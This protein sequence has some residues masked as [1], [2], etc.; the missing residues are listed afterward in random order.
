MRRFEVLK[1]MHMGPIKRD[2]RPGDVIG[3]DVPSK[4]MTLN[5]NKLTEEKGMDLAEVIGIFERQEKLHPDGPWAKEMDAVNIT[6]DQLDVKTGTQVVLPI[7]GCLKAAEE[8]LADKMGWGERKV[9]WTPQNENQYQ[10]LQRFLAS[11]PVVNQLGENLKYMADR[12]VE[13]INAWLKANDF[14]IQLSPESGDSFAVASILDVL[15]HWLTEGNVT[16]FSYQDK[17]YPAVS[18]NTDEGA[19]VVKYVNRANH[20]FPIV[21]LGTKTGDNVFM[22]VLDFMPNSTFAITEKVDQLRR[23]ISGQS[24]SRCDGVIFPMV[25]YKQQVDISWL[26]GLATGS[27]SDDWFV[28]Q[29]I[30]E[31][32]FR[33]NELGAHAKSAV[34]MSFRCM[35]L[36][37]TDWVHIDKPFILWIERPGVDMAL[38]AGVFAQDVWKKP[39]KL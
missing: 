23:L 15:V 7:L 29:A 4:T 16:S 31:T 39:A 21:K 37:P 1:G 33:M 12:D 25:D 8:F 38:F 17:T 24:G 28:G 20:P 14:D 10:F 26:R 11:K 34:A 13:V 9:E 19:N 36:A 22:S 5:G 35:A 18:I 2:I 6:M 3:W 30:Q 32:Q 27:N